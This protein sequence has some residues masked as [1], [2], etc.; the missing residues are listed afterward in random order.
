[1]P[2][3]TPITEET[4]LNESEQDKVRRL[5]EDD[6]GPPIEPNIQTDSYTLYPTDENKII[7]MNKATAVNLT[8]PP[9]SSVPFPINTRILFR[10]KGAGQVTLVPGSGVTLESAVGLKTALQYSWG[11]IIKLAVNTWGVMGDMTT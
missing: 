6:I 7:D 9:N 11:G 4:Y 2:E 8:V 10:Q 5:R 1:M 3:E